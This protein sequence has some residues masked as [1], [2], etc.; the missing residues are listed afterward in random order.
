MDPETAEVF[1][2]VLKVM[3]IVALIVNHSDGGWEF[4]TF[5]CIKK[6]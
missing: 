2:F 6:L 4:T 3:P 5:L 1:N